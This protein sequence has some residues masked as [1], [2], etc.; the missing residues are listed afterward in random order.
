M[1]FSVLSEEG[2]SRRARANMRSYSDWA[3]LKSWFQS[4][5]RTF[6]CV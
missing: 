6:A 3:V 4:Q 1:R 2:G 5:F